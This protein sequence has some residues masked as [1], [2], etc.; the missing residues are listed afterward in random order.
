MPYKSEKIPIA[1]TRL[2]ARRKL[3]NEQKEAIKLLTAEGYSQRKL[4]EMFGC[5]RW[6]VQNILRPS[7]RVKD[8]PRPREYWT[9]RKRQYRRRKQ[10]LFVDG[11]LKPLKLKKK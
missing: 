6:S 1:G 11:I 8:R 2:D 10:K 9:A 4:A 3:S 5:S 7:P